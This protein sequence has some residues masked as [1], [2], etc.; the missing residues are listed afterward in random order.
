MPIG[1][2]FEGDWKPPEE[3]KKQKGLIGFVMRHG[4]KSERQANIILIIASAMF[5]LAAIIVALL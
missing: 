4:A 2:Q 5:F 1:V 3:E